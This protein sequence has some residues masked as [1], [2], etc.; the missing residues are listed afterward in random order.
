MISANIWALWQTPNLIEPSLAAPEVR[1]GTRHTLLELR[2]RY[3]QLLK[4]V[5]G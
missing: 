2:A 3:R 4:R 5:L 1:T